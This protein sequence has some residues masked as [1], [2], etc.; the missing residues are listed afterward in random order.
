MALDRAART[1]AGHTCMTQF[2]IVSSGVRHPL[3]MLIDPRLTGGISL[4]AGLTEKEAQLVDKICGQL[5]S[6]AE[7][8]RQLG[9]RLLK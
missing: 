7:V 2:H 9:W 6:E 1:A 4:T 8:L 5:A 3:R